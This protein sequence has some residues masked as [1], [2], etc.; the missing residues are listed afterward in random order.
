MRSEKP[1]SDTLDLE[2]EIAVKFNKMIRIG[3][4]EKEY[5]DD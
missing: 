4:A 1:N 5:F 3:V 2:I